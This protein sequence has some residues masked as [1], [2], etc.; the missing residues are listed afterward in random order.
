MHMLRKVAMMVAF[1]TTALFL[2]AQ[3]I[4][5]FPHTED[6]ESFALCGVNCGDVCPLTNG[7]T[8]V[9][10]DAMDWTVSQGPTAT[11]NTG[12]DIDHNPG[13]ATGNYLYTET[14]GTCTNL[15]AAFTTPP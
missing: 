4:S 8:N 6:F 15:T 7:W 10:N 2:H 1:T 5:S 12:P 9:T 11:L 14:S 3:T 13:N